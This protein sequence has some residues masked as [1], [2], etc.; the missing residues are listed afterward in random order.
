MG[1]ARAQTTSVFQDLYYTYDPAGNIAHIRDDAQQTT[2]FNNQVVPPTCDYVYDPIYRLTQASGREHVGQLAQPQTNWDDR[3][4]TNLP[5]PTDGVA[6]R[7]YTEQY[8]YDAVGNFDR[9]V[10][11]AAGGNWT[12]TYSYNE[13]SLVEAAKKSNRLSSTAVGSTTDPYTF[14][15]HGNTTAMPH[16]TLMQ[17]DFKDQLGATSRQ[18]VVGG[19]NTAETTYY[20]YDSAGQRVRKVTERQDGTAKEERIYL[21]GFEVYRGFAANGAVALE[22]ETLHVMDDK[23]RVAL[24]ETRTLGSDGSLGQ[25]VRY[26]FG[27]HLGSASLEMDGAGVVISY[28]EYFPYGSTSYQAVDQAIKAAA[29]RYRYTGKERDEE[30]GLVIMGRGTTRRGWGGG[31]AVIR[32]PPSVRDAHMSMY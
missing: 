12:R 8:F 11:Q 22:R 7:S 2:Y 28:E 27:N 3:F 13:A 1:R 18:S 16:L 10:H 31:L 15:A 29:K 6:M 21:G 32:Q 25:L 19:G 9:M 14:N 26:Q 4:R 5:L 17:W 20:V 30:T 24:V 23:Q